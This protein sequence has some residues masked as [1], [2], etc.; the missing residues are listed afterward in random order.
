MDSAA[1]STLPAAALAGIFSLASAPA[2]AYVGGQTTRSIDLVVGPRFVTRRR[3]GWPTAT[4]EIES[5]LCATPPRLQ[6]KLN[7]LG[8]FDTIFAS[9]TPA[10][11]CTV[12]R[13]RVVKQDR[14]RRAQKINFMKTASSSCPARQHIEV[15]MPEEASFRAQL[16]S[17]PPVN[18]SPASPSNR[19]RRQERNIRQAQTCRKAKAPPCPDFQP[20]FN[21]P[22]Q[23]CS[24]L[25]CL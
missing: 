6:R 15:A 3:R 13:L 22:S 10:C 18:S 7:L 19:H 17:H 4:M 14:G 9:A 23:C 5:P 11:T 8:T 12:Y 21:F 2:F 24:A 1:S 20:Q 16:S 25:P